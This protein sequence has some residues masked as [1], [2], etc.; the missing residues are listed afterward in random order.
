MTI[1]GMSPSVAVEGSA[2]KKAFEAYV[3]RFLV[4]ALKPERIVLLGYLQAK[5]LGCASR[6]KRGAANWFT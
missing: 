4:P 3:E 1:E 2:T 5:A 6:M